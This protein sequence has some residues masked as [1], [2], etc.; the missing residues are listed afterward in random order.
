[1][2]GSMS[3]SMSGL[4]FIIGKVNIHKI[5]ITSNPEIKLRI[6]LFLSMS[7]PF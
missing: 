3:G 4:Y 1:M 5:M 2:S 6:V 7:I